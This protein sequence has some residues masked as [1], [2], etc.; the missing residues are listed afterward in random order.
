MN[1][2]RN[3]LIIAGN[4]LSISLHHFANDQL[5]AWHPSK[6]LDWD[7]RNP[8]DAAMRLLD[9]LPN[10]DSALLALD[11]DRFDSH[12]EL[13]NHINTEGLALITSQG[14]L[15]LKAE[16][17]QFLALS[18]ANFDHHAAKVTTTDWEWSRYMS[19]HADEILGV[20]SFNYD[21][22]LERLLRESHISYFSPEV[23]G[24]SEL[25]GIML[26]K[27]HGSIDFE[28]SPRAISIPAPAFPLRNY[29]VNNDTGLQRLPMDQLIRARAQYIVVPPSEASRIG[30]YQWVRPIFDWVVRCR[31][32]IQRIVI[33][34]LSYHPSDRIEVKRILESVNKTTEIVLCNPEVPKALIATLKKRGFH[35]R[36]YFSGAPT[37]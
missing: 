30:D 14:N 33:V 13:L 24:E 27:P 2:N 35:H 19:Q 11:R 10:L 31:P 5:R 29:L 6:P 8:N 21:L 26:G 36:R 28:V 16:L 37:E 25:V 18:Y 4:G 23:D 12:F 20:L 9:V 17:D 22:I 7:V 15:R 1:T 3:T 34:G 32:Q